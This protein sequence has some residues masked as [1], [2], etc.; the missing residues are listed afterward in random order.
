MLLRMLRKKKKSM[1]SVTYP[2]SPFKAVNRLIQIPVYSL[3][4]IR[5]PSSLRIRNISNFLGLCVLTLPS[6]GSNYSE[7]DRSESVVAEYISF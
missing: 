4:I 5:N 3:F 2:L 1:I 6:S 7:R